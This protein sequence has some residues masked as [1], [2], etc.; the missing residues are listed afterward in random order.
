MDPLYEEFGLLVRE[1]RSGAGVSQSELARRIGLSRT[2]VTNIERGRQ[3]VSLRQL[4]EIARAL[5]STPERLLPQ[6]A[7]VAV[8]SGALRAAIKRKGYNED[9]AGLAEHVWV[10]T[11][12][13]GSNASAH[14]PERTA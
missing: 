5:D 13:N 6:R 14:Q 8:V 9:V 7:R 10:A 11:L 4:F 12:S 3:H 2:S 1:A